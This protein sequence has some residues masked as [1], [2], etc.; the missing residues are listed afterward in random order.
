M[1]VQL[2]AFL[3][4]TA[5]GGEWLNLRPGH[6]VPWRVSGTYWIGDW[7]SLRA[8]IDE[9]EKIKMSAPV[10]NRIPNRWLPRDRI[11]LSTK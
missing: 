4:A 3:T 8:G 9:V 6:P 1:K 5:G 2:H 7:V 10:G 11:L